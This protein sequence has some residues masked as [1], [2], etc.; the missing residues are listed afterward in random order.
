MPG[1]GPIGR[2]IPIMPG[3]GP[4]GLCISIMPGGGGLAWEPGPPAI[5]NCPGGGRN[6]IPGGGPI[7]PLGEALGGGPLP[8]LMF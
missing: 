5:G 2:Y 7:F 8:M 3:G 1:G 6:I 4:I